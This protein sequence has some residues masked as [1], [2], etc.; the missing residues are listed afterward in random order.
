MISVWKMTF[1]L[2][3]ALVITSCSSS[4]KAIVKESKYIKPELQN[5]AQLLSLQISRSVTPDP[6][7]TAKIKEMLITAR[8]Y[9]SEIRNVHVRNPWNPTQLILSMKGD[10]PRLKTENPKQ[11]GYAEL[12]EL[13]K[14]YPVEKIQFMFKQNYTLHF[15][16]PINMPILVESYKKLEGVAFAEI[17]RAA[18]DGDNIVLKRD[19]EGWELTFIRGWGDC[20]AGCIHKHFWD[21]RFDKEGSITEFK[22]R[23]DPV[24]K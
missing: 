17:D 6:V 12:D 5:D 18:G 20:P 9:T 8:S 21:F 11:T 16:R 3:I 1:F 19:G 2:G 15:V 13:N 22:E 24:P 7:L 14:T 23:G 4:N 10:T